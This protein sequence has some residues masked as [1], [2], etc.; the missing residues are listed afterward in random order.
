MT[1]KGYQGA[2]EIARQENMRPINCQWTI[3]APKNNKVN[4]TFTSFK[5]VTSRL[6]RID[7]LRQSVDNGCNDTHLT[8][9]TSILYFCH[10]NFYVLFNIYVLN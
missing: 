5:M 8:V 4:I 7:R 2:I 10:Q 9:S 6:K 1:I 3:V